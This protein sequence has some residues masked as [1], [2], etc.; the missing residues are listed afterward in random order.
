M[1]FSVTV[2]TWLLFDASGSALANARFY[3][4][5][6]NFS[7]GALAKSLGFVSIISRGIAKLDSQT[8]FLGRVLHATVW[9]SL[10]GKM[11]INGSTIIPDRIELD[12]ASKIIGTNLAL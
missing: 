1:Q 11:P 9:L 4:Q 6:A 5:R 12:Y 8:L 7:R 2:E 10:T 3:A